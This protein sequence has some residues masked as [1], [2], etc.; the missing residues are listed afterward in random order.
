MKKQG[1]TAQD[2]AARLDHKPTPKGGIRSRLA[3]LAFAGAMYASPARADTASD[4]FSF[5]VT[6]G[7][8]ATANTAGAVASQGVTFGAVGF[9]DVVE[10][11]ATGFASNSNSA[12]SSVAANAAANAPE[13]VSPAAAAVAAVAAAFGPNGPEAPNAAPPDEEDD[14]N[15]P[16]DLGDGDD[17]CG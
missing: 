10:G 17:G 15:D 16:G 7:T 2:L 13:G 4:N 11:L 12:I 9:G 5:G 1:I 3:L 6:E 14:Q 8:N